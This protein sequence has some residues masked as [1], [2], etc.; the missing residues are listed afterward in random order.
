MNMYD[1]PQMLHHFITLCALLFSVAVTI[2][3]AFLQSL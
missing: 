3:T 2:I 1:K